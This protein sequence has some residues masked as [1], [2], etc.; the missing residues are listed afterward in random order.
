MV[1][2]VDN[3]KDL[4]EQNV[5]LICGYG[6]AAECKINIK[7]KLLSFIHYQQMTEILT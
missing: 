5:K 3:L 4:K 6:K 2:Y 1:V 7:R